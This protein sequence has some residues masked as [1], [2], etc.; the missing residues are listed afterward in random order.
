MRM[1]YWRLYLA[2]AATKQGYDASRRRQLSPSSPSGRR[3]AALRPRV[4]IN[5]VVAMIDGPAI[6]GFIG[7]SAAASSAPLSR[8][9]QLNACRWLLSSAA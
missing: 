1:P 7:L 6:D 9:K 2:A 3:R 8:Q 4:V 5:A